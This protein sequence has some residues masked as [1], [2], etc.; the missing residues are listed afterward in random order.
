MCVRCGLSSV[1][2]NFVFF[3]ITQ[4]NIRWKCSKEKCSVC[5]AVHGANFQTNQ[6]QMCIHTV[7]GWWS[8]CFRLLPS[9]CLCK[10]LVFM[11]A[12][13]YSCAC[14]VLKINVFT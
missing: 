12:C 2:P 4:W 7:L 14:V 1:S 11:C 10:V 9:M 6:I 8:K 3:Y 5:C 13:V